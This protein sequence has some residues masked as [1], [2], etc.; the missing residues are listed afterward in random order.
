MGSVWLNGRNLAIPSLAD[1]VRAYGASEFYRT[2]E[3][4]LWKDI[5][6]ASGGYPG[7]SKGVSHH[8]DAG[9]KAMD[10]FPSASYETYRAVAKP[11]TNLHLSRACD[12]FVC[13][14]GATNTIGAGGPMGDFAYNDG[15]AWQIGIEAGNNGLGE[16]WPDAQVRAYVELSARLYIGYGKLFGWRLPLDPNQFFDHRRWA[17]GRKIDRKGEA[18]CTINGVRYQFSTGYNYWNTTLYYNVVSMRVEQITAPPPTPIPTPPTPTPDP[19]PPQPQPYPPI[20]QPIPGDLDMA[21][22]NIILDTRNGGVYVAGDNTKTWCNNGDTARQLRYRV[23]EAQG[24]QP[25][26]NVDAAPFPASLPPTAGVAIDGYHYSVITHGDP[27]FIASFGPF[28][29]PR[30]GGVDEYGR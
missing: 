11:I 15:N 4:D 28:V 18:G 9:S 20:P 25:N 12:V 7:R 3:M 6:R 22:K 23:M 8:H 2:I 19:T 16:V 14:A 26:Y 5:S 1:V 30:P 17:P 21:I 10:G 29:G 27:H 13:A 24:I